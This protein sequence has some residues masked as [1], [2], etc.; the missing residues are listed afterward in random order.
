MKSSGK[1]FSFSA[2]FDRRA[3]L[4]LSEHAQHVFNYLCRCMNRAGRC[5]PSRSAIAHAC[6]ISVKTVERALADLAERNMI[7][8]RSGA[9][10]STNAY[11]VNEPSVWRAPVSATDPSTQSVTESLL[12]ERHTVALLGEPAQSVTQSL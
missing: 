9:Y 3:E 6:D 12:S 1:H 4:R 2:V 10:G 8:Y 7:D 5:F 11:R